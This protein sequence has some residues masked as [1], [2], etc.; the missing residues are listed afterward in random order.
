[1]ISP[2]FNSPNPRSL[3]K[4]LSVNSL[5][6]DFAFFTA[7][8]KSG[9]V[10]LAPLKASICSFMVLSS[11]AK[12]NNFLLSIISPFDDLV[13]NLLNSTLSLLSCFIASLLSIF[14]LSSSCYLRSFAICCMAAS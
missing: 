10:M 2:I 12:S 14:R 5:R 8:D 13:Y 11:D 6:A 7:G 1:M 9:I 4:L 3:K